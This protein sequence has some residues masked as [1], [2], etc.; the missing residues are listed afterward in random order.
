[1]IRRFDFYDNMSF[2]DLTDYLYRTTMCWPHWGRTVDVEKYDIINGELVP[3]K[4]YKD[5][6]LK[7][8]EEELKELDDYYERRK[9]EIADER[10]RLTG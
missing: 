8:K 1:M 2:S 6:L 10:K 4:D 5:S 9:K 7:Q 3:R